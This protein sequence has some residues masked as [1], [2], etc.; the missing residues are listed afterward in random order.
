M[1]IGWH[2]AL[3]SQDGCLRVLRPTPTVRQ[4]IELTRLHRLF[5]IVDG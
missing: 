5:E 3:R 2:K 1:L 4:I